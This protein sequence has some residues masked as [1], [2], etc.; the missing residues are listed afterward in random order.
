MAAGSKALGV[1]IAG[2]NGFLGSH[3]ARS[4]RKK[5]RVVLSYAKNRVPIDGVLSLPIDVRD[6]TG[7]QKILRTQKPD[8]VIYLG[9]PE[10]H[11]WVDSNP[12]LAEKI[13]ATGPGDLIHASDLLSARFFYISG[14]SVFDGTKGNYSE[15]DHLSPMTLLGKLKARGETLVR[16][17]AS[18][19]T[20]LRLSPLVGSSHPWR[21][22]L[23]DQIR[24]AL[25]FD[26]KIELPDDEYYSWTTVSDAVTVI[27]ALIHEG[28]KTALYHYGGLTRLTPYEMAKLFAKTIGYDDS[29]IEKCIFIKK[30]VLQKGMIILSEGQK[31]DF[32]L[33]SSEIMKKIGVTTKKIETEIAREFTFE[34]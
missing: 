12:K 9:G 24:T 30:R 19:A 13:F 10:D 6:V 23:F 8:I 32:S 3:L 18:S 27:E 2:G 31:Y 21:P 7:S 4:L 29:K 22:S 16:G 25:E 17:R 11:T 34:D 33:N 1:F 20:V 15:L 5:A 26:Q 28:S 14:A